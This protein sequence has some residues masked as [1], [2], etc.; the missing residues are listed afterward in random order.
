MNAIVTIAHLT[1]HEAARRRILHAALAGGLAFLLL[2]AVGFHFVAREAQGGGKASLLEQRVLLNF[3]TLAGCYCAN[4]LGLIA[5]VLLP[6]DTLSGEIASGVM[7]TLAARPVRRS[8]IVL[9][10]WIGHGL[11]VCG[12]L[13]LLLGG[14]LVVARIVGHFTPPGILQGVP[15]LFLEALVMLTLSIAG[16]SR[17]A[18]VTNGVVAFG[19]FGIAFLGGW[20]EQVGTFKDSEATRTIGTI[21]S[22]V[23]PTEALWQRAAHFMQPPIMAELAATPFSPASVPS[24]AMVVWA[25]GWIAVVL[26]L[27]LASFRRRGL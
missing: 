13:T 18:T 2:Y 5:A 15:L 21:A 12:Y 7:Q 20:I 8:D 19:M 27:A 25:A 24:G 4:F 6:L 11:V 16:G 1:L 26:S 23:M 22:L 17:L 10:K 3:F 14:V 9:G